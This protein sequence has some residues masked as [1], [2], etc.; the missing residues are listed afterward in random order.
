MMDFNPCIV[1]FFHGQSDR[2]IVPSPVGYSLQYDTKGLQEQQDQSPQRLETI[3]VTECQ[4][5]QLCNNY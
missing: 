2:P 5:P 3:F 1:Q 4:R